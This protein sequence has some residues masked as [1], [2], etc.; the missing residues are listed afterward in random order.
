M[1]NL[2]L[3]DARLNVAQLVDDANNRRW[4]TAQVDA[5]LA[6]ALS[7]CLSQY[8]SHGGTAFDAEVVVSSSA[9]GVVALSTVAPILD[10]RSV[11]IQFGS[12]TTLTFAPCPAALRVDRYAIENAVYSVAV[13]YVRDYRLSAT[14]SDPL[15]GVAAVE[16]ASWPDF[17]RWI[18]ADAAASLAIKDNDQRPGLAALE[19]KA[20]DNVLT[21]VVT[22]KAFPLTL[23]RSVG[24]QQRRLSYVL[25][26]SAAAPTLQLVRAR[27]QDG[28]SGGW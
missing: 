28:F 14:G 22:P 1:A 24:M 5:A 18:C 16:A 9:A 15:V 27:G 4:S 13:T 23:P 12:G 2:T 26:S 25:T 8:V 19:Q 3:T 11:S 17:E 21:R 10:I 6:Q 20:K 7:G